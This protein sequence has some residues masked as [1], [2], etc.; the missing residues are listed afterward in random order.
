[1]SP[2][3][4]ALQ[5]LNQAAKILDLDK[6][7]VEVLAKPQRIIEVNVPLRRDN[8]VLEHYTGFRVQHNDAR[9][10]FKGGLRFHNQVN[11]DEIKALAFWM[12]IKTA[13]VGIP[14]GGGKGGIIIDPASLSKSEL[15]RLSR[16]FV[17]RIKEFIGSQKDVPAP[18]VNTT[19]QIMAWLVDEYCRLTGQNDLGAITGKPLIYGG[20]QGRESAT[21]QGGFYILAELA[22]KINL[23]P[24][25]TSIIIQGFGN[26][27]SHFA[28][29]AQQGG[30]KI[31]GLSDSSG[32]IYSPDGFAPKAVLKFK[33]QGQKISQYS[34]GQKMSNEELLIQACDILAPAALEDV[35]TAKNAEQI[36]AKIILELANGPTT[37]EAEIILRQKNIIIAPDVLVNAGGVTVSYFEWAQ[38]KSG[39]YWD[40]KT[41]LERLKPIMVKSFEAIWQLAKEKNIDLR[42][43]AFAIAV[44]RIVDAM[45][46]RGKI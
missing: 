46:A 26:V 38:N 28:R 21:G 34:Q 5:Q 25:E 43:A 27:G 4:N 12:S 7:T 31:V 13:V 39:F 3:Q 37:A 40:E 33:N 16:A 15:Q 29:L 35:I 17:G 11:L 20:S 23:I 42:Q 14:F 6:T 36:K 9:G 1:M 32:A 10:P 18:D 8:G 2:W 24:K 22:K 19:P 44:Q 41:V 30:Y 45:E